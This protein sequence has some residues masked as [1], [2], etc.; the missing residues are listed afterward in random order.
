MYRSTQVLKRQKRL[1]PE[2]KEESEIH[3]RWEGREGER[4]GREGWEGTEGRREV[5]DVPV[6]VSRAAPHRSP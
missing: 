1:T 2:S 6:V 4:G 5:R 3:L